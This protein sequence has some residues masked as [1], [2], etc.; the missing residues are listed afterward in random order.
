[1]DTRANDL[2]RLKEISC[3]LKKQPEYLT[4]WF[5]ARLALFNALAGIPSAETPVVVG[6]R[7]RLFTLLKF[8]GKPND[9]WRKDE[10][11]NLYWPP[12]QAD[13]E[14]LGG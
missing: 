12:L 6:L 3:T 14:A 9:R 13:I 4:K 11:I 1:M 7:D 10:I 5:V 2:M 8:V